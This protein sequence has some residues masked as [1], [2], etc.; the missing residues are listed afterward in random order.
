[1]N[2]ATRARARAIAALIRS[3]RVK[4][5][6]LSITSRFKEEA[7]DSYSEHLAIV[8]ANSTPSESDIVRSMNLFAGQQPQAF[9]TQDEVVK[10]NRERLGIQF[11]RK[12]V[13]TDVT[14]KVLDSM[15]PRE[16]LEL[17]NGG[18]LPTRFVLKPYGGG[19]DE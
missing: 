13:I 1:M 18:S 8:Y 5:G 16:R 17:A 11:G 2:E 19:D 6:P 9:Y 12:K 10:Q 7:I 3:M 15:T 14:R 4:R